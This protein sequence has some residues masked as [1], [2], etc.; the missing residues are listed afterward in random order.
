MVAATVK[1]VSFVF[2]LAF[3]TGCA[4]ISIPGGNLLPLLLLVKEDPQHRPPIDSN[5]QRAVFSSSDREFFLDPE[6]FRTD[7]NVSTACLGGSDPF[8]VREGFRSAL[9]PILP[10]QTPTLSLPSATHR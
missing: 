1:F 9:V 2:L 10:A 5:R 4:G 8:L 7:R 6:S 3:C